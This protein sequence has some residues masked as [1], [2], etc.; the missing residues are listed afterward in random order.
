MKLKKLLSMAL[1]CTMALACI[2]GCGEKKQADDGKI[3]IS[4]AQWP[5]EGTKSYTAQMEM[6][7]KFNEIYPDIEIVGDTYKYDIST[8]TAKATAGTMPTLYST[9]FTEVDKIIEAGYAAELTDAL[10]DA[11]WLS[12]MNQDIIKYVSNDKGKVY[13]IPNKVYAQGLY[14]NKALFEQ[15]GL[16][17]GNGEI[18]IP[19]TFDDVYESAKAIKE[20]T[21]KA[22]FG[23]ATINNQGGWHTI[24]IA[25][26]HGT[27]FLNKK[28]G[29]YTSAL[30]TPETV[31]AYEWVKKMRAAKV[32][33]DN[34]NL[35]ANG[36]QELYG[37]GQLGMF[38]GEP[39]YINGIVMNYGMKPENIVMTSMPAG[40]AGSFAQ[41][42]G[43]LY[44]IDANATPE[45]IDA[46][47]K[48]IDFI[49]YGPTL[50]EEALQNLRV[51]H[52]LNHEKGGVVLPQDAFYLW[53]NEDS[54]AKLLKTR[55][56][57]VNIPESNLETYYSF[58]GVTLM[59]EPE[60]GCQ[61]LYAELDKIVQEIYANSDADVAA[62]VKSASNNWQ[63]NCLDNLK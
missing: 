28:D 37:S 45:Q 48:W 57:L 47:L 20:K 24:N 35:K 23:L 29:K 15:A 58:E 30:D 63:V 46:C 34:P 22:G 5:E 13:G 25:W 41:M 36:L 50:T 53:T 32:F 6:V 60:V 51:T 1:V 4:V 14:I 39:D 17:D 2:P 18:I 11:D 9:W 56:G 3:R 62:M 55:E 26:A 59:P 33:P 54:I 27:E 16:V 8:F 61:E 12:Q 7:A 52:E 43:D 19:K 10:K 31:A 40:P 21:G 44:M 42:G 38:I 49:G